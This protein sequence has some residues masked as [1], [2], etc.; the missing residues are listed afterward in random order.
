MSNVA[1]KVE[2]LGKMYRIGGKQAAYSTFRETLTQAIATPFRKLYNLMRGQSYAAA[3]LEEEIW[4]LRDVSFEIKHGE[5]LGI[6]GRNGAGKSTLLKILSRIT[7]PTTGYADIYGRVGALLEVGTGFHPELTGRENIFLN[8][9]ILGMSR[10]DIARKF[11]EIVAFADVEKFIDTPVKYYSSG[12]GLRLGFAVAAHLEPEILIVDEVLAVGDTRF[13]KKCLGKMNDV[14]TE[15]RTVLFVSHNM[16]AVQNL[17]QRSIWLQDGQVVADGSTSEIVSQYL[18]NAA[19]SASERN[20]DNIESAPGNDIVRL[21]RLRVVPN[22]DN[23]NAPITMTTPL[24]L[25]FE[26]WNLKPETFLNLSLVFYSSDGVLAFNTMPVH[27][28]EWVTRPFPKGLFRSVCYVP[29]YLLNSG[30]YRISCLFVQDQARVIY[31]LD[32]ALTLDV[33]E[34]AEVRGGMSWFGRWPGVV[35]PRLEWRTEKLDDLTD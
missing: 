4:A 30:I 20:Y 22:G 2:Q 29:A 15:G 8:G 33:A 6:I 21:R 11:D 26:Y 12:M 25:E 5:V 27:D 28:L 18:N 1:I 35:H 19:T 16:G 10:Q 31:R 34:A 3:G 14:A 17:C 9:A 24:R 32:D 13:Q 7:E 23:P